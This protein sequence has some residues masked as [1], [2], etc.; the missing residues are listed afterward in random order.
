MLVATI[1]IVAMDIDN[2][3][4]AHCCY[5]GELLTST[6]PVT[7]ITV[8]TDQIVHVATVVYPRR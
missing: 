3:S 8:A 7:I 6:V 1:K 5:L 4:N 2:I